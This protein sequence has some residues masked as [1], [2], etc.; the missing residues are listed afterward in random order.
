MSEELPEISC[1]GND[2]AFGCAVNLP[3]GRTAYYP[4]LTKREY[5]ALLIY[6]RYEHDREMDW[7][8]VSDAIQMADELIAALNKGEITQ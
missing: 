5:F 2:P 3:D 1:N 7:K 4:G 6:C 8:T